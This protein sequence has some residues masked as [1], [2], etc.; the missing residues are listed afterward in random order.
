MEIF[1]RDSSPKLTT[2]HVPFY[3]LATTAL[4]LFPKIVLSRLQQ[5]GEPIP[6][7][8]KAFKKFGHKL[9]LI[10]SS[11]GVGDDFLLKTRISKVVKVSDQDQ[12]VYR[13]D[14]YHNEAGRP[15]QIYD[16][17]S[18]RYGFMAGE[19]SNAGIV[20]YQFDELLSL[21]QSVEKAA[22]IK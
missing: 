14:F 10:Y 15:I 17:E 19:K 20:A 2:W 6:Q 1:L 22:N 11:K 13:F 7:I 3:I 16:M 4:E 8:I 18:L 5:N 12:F 9:D 21:C